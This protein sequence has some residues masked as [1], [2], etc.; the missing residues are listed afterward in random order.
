MA[1][2]YLLGYMNSNTALFYSWNS[3]LYLTEPRGSADD[4]V[5]YLLKARIMEQEKTPVARER[6]CKHI[7]C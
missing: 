5:A 1:R 3:K 2:P 7:H 4:N 6:L